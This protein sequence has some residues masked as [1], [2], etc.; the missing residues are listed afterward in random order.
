[1]LFHIQ[2]KYK[3]FKINSAVA[4]FKFAQELEVEIEKYLSKAVAGLEVIIDRKIQESIFKKI[5]Q[6]EGKKGDQGIPGVLGG[7]GDKGDSITGLKGEKGNSGISGKDGSIG[8]PGKDGKLGKDGKDGK[9]P[10]KNIDYFT[11]EELEY[12]MGQ[13]VGM[14]KLKP[15]EK[16]IKEIL[17]KLERTE[18]IRRLGGQRVLHRGGIDFEDPGLLGTYDGSTLVFTL[19]STPYTSNSLKHI[20]VGG[21]LLF[22]T[23]DWTRNGQSITLLNAPP[24]GAKVRNPSYR[25][26]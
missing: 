6:I 16:Q 13:V 2:L 23:D 22:E 7:K 9:T 10:L 24:D 25:K 1:M 3:S 4:L 11:K 21:G 20:F 26:T 12:F 19:P 14:I 15:L 17:K 5:K 8:I 18:E